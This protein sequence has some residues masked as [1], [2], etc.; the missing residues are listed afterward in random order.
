MQQII[1]LTV[2]VTKIPIIVHLTNSMNLTYNDRGSVLKPPRSIICDMQWCKNKPV[3]G[4]PQYS[5][6]RV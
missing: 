3:R 5:F 4:G 2:V 1:Q 6:L